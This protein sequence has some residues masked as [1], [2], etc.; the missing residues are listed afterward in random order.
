MT[1]LVLMSHRWFPES[2]PDFNLEVEA[3]TSEEAIAIAENF[4]QTEHHGFFPVS[5]KRKRGGRRPGAGG[6]GGSPAKYGMKTKVVRVPEA[7]ADCV[8]ALLNAVE[9]VDR[10]VKLYDSRVEESRNRTASGQ[11]AER[12]KYLDEFLSQLEPDIEVFRRVNSL[13]GK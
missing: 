2:I 6:K 13:L 9:S 3:E 4:A 1:W 11:P 10:L 8:P 5:T 7:I 12:Y